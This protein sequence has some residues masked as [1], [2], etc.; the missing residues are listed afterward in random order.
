MLE[1]IQAAEQISLFCRLNINTKRELPIRSSEMGM[2]IY[3]CKS[4][5]DKTPMGV[6]RFFN[7]SKAMATNMVTSLYKK[8]YIEKTPSP[9]DGRSLL[10]NPTEKAKTLVDSTYDEYFKTMAVLKEQMGEEDFKDFLSLLKKANSILLEE[11][12]N[13]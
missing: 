3:L 13:G 6:A 5:R 2:L 4:D 8:D 1:I 11:K 7:V 9:S 12:N 10:L